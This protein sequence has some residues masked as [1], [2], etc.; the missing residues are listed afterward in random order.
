MLVD[1]W[2]VVGGVV[3]LSV[4]QFVSIHHQPACAA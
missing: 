1:R 4:Q 2:G 3:R